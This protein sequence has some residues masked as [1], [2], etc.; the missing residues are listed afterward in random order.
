MASA[1]SSRQY[2]LQ[3]VAPSDLIRKD[4]FA[5]DSRDTL[6]TTRAV[7]ELLLLQSVEGRAH[8]G[9]G[10]FQRR[11][12]PNTTLDDVTRALRLDPALIRAE[13]QALIN[14]MVRYADLALRGSA[15]PALLDE[16]NNPLLGI[17]FLRFLRV[18][19]DD[20]LRGL[21]LGGLR[22]DPDI[23]REVERRRGVRIGG[24]RS[25][26]VS[27]P[28]MDALGLDA[29]RLAHGEW[30]EELESFR[31]KGLIVAADR[32]NDPGVARLYIRHRPG[33]GASDDSAIVGAGMLW[34]L[35]VAVGVFFAD[36]IDTLEKY[37]PVYR[38]QDEEIAARIEREFPSLNMG[39]EEA[40]T[41]T[42]LAAIPEGVSQDVPDS[43]LRHLLTIDRQY[44]LCAIEAHFLAVENI[45]APS[46][47]LSHER[48]PSREFYAYLRERVRAL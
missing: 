23:R 36:A 3:G 1:G 37:V 20:V 45:P 35:G 48:T 8:E 16:D 27:L 43:S 31:R 9:H 41:L 33:S 6:R 2:R 17:S 11:R 18:S 34:G 5:L 22:D 46:I 7:E 38:D 25:Y 4:F 47:G 42:W 29:E 39:R 44:D 10:L 32:Q 14:A 24:G 28:Q 13:R 30:E 21:Y 12:Y 26:L 40:Y 15:P 19:P